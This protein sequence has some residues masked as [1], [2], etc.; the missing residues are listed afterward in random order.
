MSYS[1]SAWSFLD[2]FPRV[3]CEEGDPWLRVAELV[4]ASEA[5]LHALGAE[6]VRLL[7]E[8]APVFA[9][10]GGNPSER[11]WSSFRPLR[12][13]REE[14]WSDWL[15]HLLASATSSLLAKEIGI[16]PDGASQ[17]GLD[18]EREV[19]IGGRRA[20]LVV[21]WPGSRNVHVEI[22]VGDKMFKKT[23]ETAG[24]L[25]ENERFAPHEWKHFILLPASDLPTWEVEAEEARSEIEVESLTWR[26]IALSL[27]RV[28]WKRKE[29]VAWRVWAWTLC[30][31]IEQLLLDLPRAEDSATNGN[32]AVIQAHVMLLQEGRAV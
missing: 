30:G 10:F 3:P 18:V 22:K 9:E 1:A 32:L 21:T 25:E 11:D 31:A 16:A 4:E 28:L 14:D 26:K 6:R 13:S 7:G 27:R 5:Y 2:A 23:F 29:P 12:L 19:P 17:D 24:L 8:W 20:D 15:G